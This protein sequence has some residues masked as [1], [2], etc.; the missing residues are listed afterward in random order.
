MDDVPEVAACQSKR[1]E[2]QPRRG[3]EAPDGQH[4]HDGD[5]FHASRLLRPTINAR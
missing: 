4:D 5:P 3:D 2:C 1:A